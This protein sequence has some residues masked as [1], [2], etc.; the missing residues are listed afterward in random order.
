MQDA[1][2]DKGN[3]DLGIVKVVE[4]P[5]Q[6]LDPLLQRLHETEMVQPLLKDN[7]RFSFSFE[8]LLDIPKVFGRDA[9]T[10]QASSIRSPSIASF[11][12]SA[13][14]DP[15][16]DI[17]LSLQQHVQ[18]HMTRINLAQ[19]RLAQ[20]IKYVD[21]LGL[22]TTQTIAV[23]LNQAKL[24]S[25]QLQ[26]AKLI[27]EQAKQSRQHTTTIFESLRRIEHLLDAEDR[28]DHPQFRARWPALQAL[29]DRAANR[30]PPRLLQKQQSHDKQ[31]RHPTTTAT[32]TTTS[33]ASPAASNATAASSSSSHQHRNTQMPQQPAP[34]SSTPSSPTAP[35]SAMQKLRSLI[36]QESSLFPTR[37]SSEKFFQHPPSS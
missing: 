36:S 14:A 13:R 16:V 34:S 27:K 9:L 18:Q 35:L 37:S 30:Q 1:N 3:D 6:E 10:S 31:S 28:A 17:L 19:R 33:I 21:H 15:L 29:H 5:S 8:Q 4:A 22:K 25:D 11:T 23:A 26:D 7:P 32:T 20:R 24:A 2:D 12:S